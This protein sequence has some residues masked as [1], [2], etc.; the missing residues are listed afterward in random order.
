MMKKLL[1]SICALALLMACS[2][3]ND[4][5]EDNGQES[6]NQGQE[7]VT[8]VQQARRTVLVYIAAENNL[9][10]FLDENLTT[11]KEGSRHLNDNQNL[12]VY[13]NRAQ[14]TNPCYMARIYQGELVDTVL[15]P[16]ELAADPTVMT[17]ILREALQR[18]PAQS[19]GLVLWGHCD[20][21]II[22]NNDSISDTRA[23]G[24]STGNNTPYMS[25]LYWMNIP[26]MSQAIA[27]GMDGNKLAFIFGDC[28]ELASLEIAYELRHLTDYLIGSPAE[29]PDGGA[30]YELNVPDFFLET[31][32]F[33]RTLIDHYYD[34]WLAEY[35]KELNAY[36]Y[37]ND[38]FGDLVGYSVPLVA[39]KSSELDQLATATSQVLGTIADKVSTTDT[40]NLTKAIY[41]SSVGKRQ[42]AYDINC[43]LKQNATPTD[44]LTWKASYDKAIPYARHS[45]I[46][47][48]SNHYLRKNMSAYFA[49]IPAEDCGSISMT[50][51]STTYQG[52]TP[53]WNK[54]LQQYQ[55]NNVIHWEQYGW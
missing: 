7:E 4:S 38:S 12:V 40:L 15:M 25:N 22:Q 31:D 39:I 54:A 9:N 18:Y 50:F 2:K 55:W 1:L 26:Q 45:V 29:I 32:D 28:C 49:Q 44:Y 11:M 42:Y 43:V 36:R 46:W 53:N 21:W 51:P 3:D 23:Y 33:Y 20:G 48:S 8:P 52:T 30:P 13:V 34:Y 24:V 19:Y 14:E 6:Q 16:D 47:F 35:Q 10:S 17:R 41:Y 37:Y 5:Q 27:D